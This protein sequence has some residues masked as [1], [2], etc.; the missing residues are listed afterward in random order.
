MKKYCLA[1][2]F[3]AL[4]F[5]L[6]SQIIIQPDK[7]QYRP[8]DEITVNAKVKG[9]LTVQDAKG[10]NYLTKE[11]AAGGKLSFTVTGALG[12][13]IIMLNNA[14]GVPLDKKNIVVDCETSV[15]D[16]D[17]MWYRFHKKLFWNIHKSERT[18]GE[19]EM[20]Q[21]KGETYTFHSC[22]LR[23]NVH[24]IQGKKYYDNHLKDALNFYAASQ[25]D[26]G[27]IFDFFMDYGGP[28]SENR[29]SNHKFM[30][31]SK[32]DNKFFERVPVEND[33]EF[34][35][36]QG[37]YEAWKASGDDTW[38]KGKLQNADKALTYDMTSEY[39]WSKKYNLLKRGLCIDTWDF[40]PRDMAALVGGDV[41][42]VKPDITKFGVFHGDNTGF[43]NS[44][45]LLSEMY[46]FAGNKEKADYWKNISVQIL[47]RLEKISWNG[48]FYTHWVPEDE[49]FNSDYGVDMKAQISLSNT[50][51]LNRGIGHDK[52]KAIIESYEDI[53]SKLDPSA[54]AEFYGIYPPFEKGFDFKKWHYVNGGVFP[55]IGGQLAHG[56]FENGYEKYGVDILQRLD[57][58]LEK[59]DN[60]FP[61]FYIGQK[62][63]EPQ[64]NFEILDL[65]KYLNA[66]VSG[67]GA[68]GV[69]GWEGRGTEN[70]FSIM[71]TGKQSYF[72]VPFETTD[73]AGN[74]R[75]AC[76]GLAAGKKY[77]QSET[78][79]V[80]KKAASIY[81]LQTLTG[82]GHI[83]GWID[84]RF[85]D[86]SA[87]R[88]YVES[89]KQIKN[90]WIPSD[91]PYTRTYGWTCRVA[92]QGN[93]NQTIVG[94]YI[95]GYDNPYPDKQIKEITFT[96]SLMSNYWFIF[97]ITLCDQPVWFEEAD[98]C[99]GWFYNWNT[100]GVVYGF[101]EG[102]CGI[103]NTGTAFS[104]VNISPRW[105]ASATKKVKVFA[106]YPESEGYAAY[107]YSL[108]EEAIHLTVATCATFCHFNILLPDIATV[109]AVG[110]NHEPAKFIINK[111]ENSS[112]LVFDASGI[113]TK[114]VEIVLKK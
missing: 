15:E 114:D 77:K 95:W 108:D 39:V 70:D 100:A 32:A 41:M 8:L 84:V 46:A 44:A 59:H 76:I 91:V 56:A 102:L 63:K 25:A 78:I 66:D 26:D 112:Y 7:F 72:N 29:F 40:Q 6:I 58:I 27:M 52:C 106:K 48:K 113:G 92:F 57:Q 14:I 51:D 65:K 24:I 97:G 93:N 4:S 12:T 17:S 31:V 82:Q 89:D 50:Y 16:K 45:R 3:M 85:A 86:G 74:G 105:A 94:N 87:I 73:P 19:F 83:A 42:E 11:I 90:W 103:Q 5:S 109:S 80:N 13:H 98:Y 33:V 107:Q 53:K 101:I 55:F 9:I 104:S 69:P 111:I 21:Y 96:H 54:P 49:N 110:I 2:A 22:W 20:I 79:P 30:K 71:P 88:Q 28:G 36:V 23:D 35:F 38:M 60:Q 10:N 18:N 43:A 64:R 81:F 68:T 61:Y 37:I 47:E 99:V 62:S 34:L 1:L 75:K 67:Q